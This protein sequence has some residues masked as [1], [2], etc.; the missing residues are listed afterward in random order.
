MQVCNCLQISIS[1]NLCS[2]AW[3][4]HGQL[5]QVRL[6]NALVYFPSSVSNPYWPLSHTHLPPYI[7]TP[8]LSSY[9]A[10]DTSQ[11]PA[12]STNRYYVCIVEDYHYVHT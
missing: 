8:N 3:H 2:V 1:F 10:E 9:I 7:M 11:N 6:L 4:V 5:G 12:N